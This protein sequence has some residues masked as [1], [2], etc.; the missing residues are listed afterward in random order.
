MAQV[1]G[2]ALHFH[3]QSSL[4]IRCMQLPWRCQC[5]AKPLAACMATLCHG[6]AS[7]LW[8]GRKEG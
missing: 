5:R 7:D 3:L 1:P 6:E 8:E 2:A 4:C